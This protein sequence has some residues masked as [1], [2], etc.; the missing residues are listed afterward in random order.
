MQV[1]VRAGGR[2]GRV[3]LGALR[4]QGAHGVL[5][6]APRAQGSGS[7]PSGNLIASGFCRS[8][9][10]ARRPGCYRRLAGGDTEASVSL[11]EQSSHRLL[12]SARGDG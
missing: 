2:W 3:G 1:K 11:D 5:K 6:E 7:G 10:A 4:P 12:S 9:P 8:Q